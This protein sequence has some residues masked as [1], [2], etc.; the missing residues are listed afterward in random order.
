MKVTRLAAVA[1]F[2]SS[3]WYTPQ[4]VV[5]KADTQFAVPITRQGVKEFAVS[6]HLLSK[7]Q[8]RWLSKAVSQARTARCKMA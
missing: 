4:N 8:A 5:L 2:T 1:T 7:L 3:N 6:T